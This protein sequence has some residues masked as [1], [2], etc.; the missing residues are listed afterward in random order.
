MQAGAE[1][2]SLLERMPSAV[3]Y[4]PTLFSEMGA[5]QERITSTYN[6]SI[7]SV[8]AV[9]VPA[10]DI[11]DPAP[12]A[13]FAHLDASVVLSRKQ[14]ELGLY[15]AI[16]PLSSSS[17]ALSTEILG[18]KHYSVAQRIGQILQRYK[19][20]QDVIAILGLD[21]LSQEDKIIVHR[22]KRI[23]K[24]LTQPLFTATFATGINGKY[25]KREQTVHD[26]S[27]ILEGKYDHIPEEAFYMVGTLEEVLTKATLL[28]E[29]A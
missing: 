13:V 21:E 7:T 2:S 19:E 25:I 14:V 22:A 29:L 20:L 9:Y 4:Q 5:F 26:F 27:E 28:K 16:D 10:D 1:V 6:G 15:P 18:E 3:G 8:Q 24:F 23:Q 12:T 11:T 17:K